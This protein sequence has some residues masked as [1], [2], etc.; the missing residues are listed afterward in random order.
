[1]KK[2]ITGA[3][4]A[5]V[6]VLS[7]CASE[8]AAIVVE[9]TDSAVIE[10]GTSVE[11]SEGVLA[12]DRNA[13]IGDTVVVGDWEVTVTKV[14]KNADSAI[15]KA[16]QFNEDPEGQYILVTYKAKYIGEE[17]KSDV[18][19]DL[20]WTYTDAD[21]VTHDESFVVT[22][23][24]EKDSATTAR[25]GGTVTTDVAID[26]PSVGGGLLTVEGYD[27]NFDAFYADFA[28]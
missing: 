3:G 9:T 24:D 27:A 22:P 20:T 14:V 15:A 2:I 16:N 6:L 17:R 7:G 4:I 12:A 11:Q 8:Q 26:V 1:M 10:E 25:K 18:E 28:L 19:S 5:A 13:T 21:A 23:M